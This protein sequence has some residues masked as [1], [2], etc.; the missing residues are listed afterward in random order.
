MVEAADSVVDRRKVR[1]VIVGGSGREETNGVGS[2]ARD[3]ARVLRA[4]NPGAAVVEAAAG[5]D[6]L[7]C[8]VAVLRDPTV[9]LSAK[10]TIMSAYLNR[11]C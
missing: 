9:G 2:A 5:E 3:G 1:A 4:E 11:L 8:V 7:E 6:A 10:A